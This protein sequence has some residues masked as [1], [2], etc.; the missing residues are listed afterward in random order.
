MMLDLRNRDFVQ[1]PAGSPPLLFVVIDTEEEFDWR[2]PL[3]RSNS[4]VHSIA[5]QYRAQEVFERYG[6]VPIYVVDYPVA[7]SEEA[8]GILRRFCEAGRCEI[9]SHL[10]PWVNPPHE[11]E[12]TAYNSYAG[13]LSPSL[14]R[15]KLEVLTE[16]IEEAF[17]IRPTVFRAGRYGLGAATGTA[18]EQLGYKID[19]S[20]VPYT[21]F[22][23]DGGPDFSAFSE[24]PY[25]F[26]ERHDLLEIPL[27][28]GFSGVFRSWGRLLYPRLVNPLGMK[29]HLPGVAARLGLLERIRLTPEGIDLAALKRLTR[30]L[31]GQ[32]C[33]IFSLTYH[34]PSLEP[35]HTPYV[36]GESDLR[37]FLET[38]D[39]YLHYFFNELNGRPTTPMALH[40]QLLPSEENEDVELRAQSLQ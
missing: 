15:T 8:A 24:H 25:R 13:N 39:G 17:G 9:G 32:G 38:L 5:A 26:G 22:A 33:R 7:A 35:G 12:V 10:H 20:V 18:L 30:S 27:S 2:L 6:V 1:L 21:S 37:V 4:A 19:V 16:K 40:R 29:F 28:C 34:S 36:R 23:D 14:E 3:S 31:L 11:E